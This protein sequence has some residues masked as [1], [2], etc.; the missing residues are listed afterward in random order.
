MED[1]SIQYVRHNGMQVCYLIFFIVSVWASFQK[2]DYNVHRARVPLGPMLPNTQYRLL[3]EK[4]QVVHKGIGYLWI[5][6]KERLC[7][8]EDETEPTILRNTNDLVEK[9]DNDIYYIGRKD[10]MIKIQ[11]QRLHLKSINDALIA[12][13]EIDRAE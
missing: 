3:N 6:G 13:P 11:G 7:Y 4:G 5:G 1:F 2:V 9:I 10:S 8:L 12:F